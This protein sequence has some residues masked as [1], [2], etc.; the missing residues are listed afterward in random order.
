VADRI[1]V[2]RQGRR[3]TTYAAK[4]T[5]MEQLVAAMTGAFKDEEVAK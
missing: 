4:E 3:V 2:M 1:Q 5:N